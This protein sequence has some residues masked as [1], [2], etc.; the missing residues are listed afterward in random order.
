ML[1]LTVNEL[2]YFYAALQREFNSLNI[3]K[4]QDS[5]V[6]NRSLRNKIR[7]IVQ[8]LEFLDHNFT[9]KICRE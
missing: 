1:K 3:D 7:K 4:D 5:I 2:E 6:S 9:V 8:E